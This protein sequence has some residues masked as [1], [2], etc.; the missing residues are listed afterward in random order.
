MLPT[1]HRYLVKDLYLLITGPTKLHYL[2][3]V[4]NNK[5]RMLLRHLIFGRKK[6]KVEGTGSIY[7]E[8]T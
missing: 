2:R 1:Y 8:F 6:R 5:Y 4:K 3:D 7:N